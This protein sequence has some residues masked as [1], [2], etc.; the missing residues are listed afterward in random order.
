MWLTAVKAL[1]VVFLVVAVGALV[2]RGMRRSRANRDNPQWSQPHHGQPG[3]VA[4]LRGVMPKTPL[5]TWT[6][7]PGQAGLPPDDADENRRDR[8]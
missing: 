3:H 7:N 6:A 8:L 4:S 1:L 5:P 2:I